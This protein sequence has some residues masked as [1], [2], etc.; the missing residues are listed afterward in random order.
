MTNLQNSDGVKILGGSMIRPIIC[1]IDKNFSESVW[2]TFMILFVG[3]YI[4]N[5]HHTKQNY[6]NL[7]QI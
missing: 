4:K 7:Q 3:V 5:L 2:S 6:S 1:I